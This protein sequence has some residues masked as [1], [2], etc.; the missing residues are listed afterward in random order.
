M[1]DTKNHAQHTALI[2]GAGSGFGLEYVKLFAQDGYAL[3]VTDKTSELV[4][5]AEEQAQ[6][7]GARSISSVAVDLQEP[8][9]AKKLFDF[10][11][12]NGIRV[13][14]LVNNAGLGIYGKLAENE[15][16]DEHELLMV[17]VVALTELCQLYLK[18]MSEARYGKVLN[19]A[20]IAGLQ[21]GF[22][23][24][25]YFASKAH[26]LLLSEA[27]ALE[28]RNDGVTV[29]AVCPGVSPTGFFNRAGMKM[30]SKLLTSSFTDPARVAKVGYDAM[31]AGKTI[32]VPGKRNWV[33][34]KSYRWLPRNVINHITAQLI[35]IAGKG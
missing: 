10:T 11:T 13:T 33:V 12:Q 2:T 34:S 20:S 19:V 32:A 26:V 16:R 23:Y 5:R 31:Q 9:A 24:A 29:T 6:A 1:I 14:H 21:A 3:V 7:F 18:P 35:R 8:F 17:N 25:T 15:A 28:H 22:M 30:S 27:L 4:R